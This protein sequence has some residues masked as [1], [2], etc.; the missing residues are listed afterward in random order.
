MRM[1]HL[2]RV[3]ESAEEAESAENCIDVLAFLNVSASLR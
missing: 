3:V 2:P 1:A